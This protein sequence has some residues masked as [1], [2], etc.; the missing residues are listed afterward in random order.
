MLAN[1][2]VGVAIDKN[3]AIAKLVFGK[4]DVTVTLSHRRKEKCG[5]DCHRGNFSFRMLMPDGLRDVIHLPWR[6]EERLQF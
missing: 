6:C 5:A 1:Q 3:K 2:E 4:R